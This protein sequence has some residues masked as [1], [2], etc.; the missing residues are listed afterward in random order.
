MML[1]M[2]VMLEKK[3]VREEKVEIMM[4]LG[5]DSNLQIHGKDL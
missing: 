4:I 3:T 5:L 2:M 1:V